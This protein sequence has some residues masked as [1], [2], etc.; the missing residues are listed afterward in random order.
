MPVS[1]KKLSAAALATVSVLASP[2]AE[3]TERAPKEPAVAVTWPWLATQLVP[4]PELVYGEDTARFGMRW[5]VTPLLYSWGIHRG[6]SPWRMFVVEPNVRHFG[7][8]ELYFTPEVVTPGGNLGSAWILR[9]GARAYFPL[10][11]HGEYLS[12]SVGASQYFYDGRSHAGYEAGIYTFFGVLGLQV[13][14]SPGF[15]PMA[16]SF[17]LSVRYF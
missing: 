5:Q 3:A 8:V 2:H 6:L 13:T 1:S 15:A 9:S 16:T 12:C 4:S 14:A 11:E 10:V 7:S 17:T